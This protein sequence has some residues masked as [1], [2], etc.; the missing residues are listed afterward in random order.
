M[1]DTKIQELLKNLKKELILLEKAK[2]KL[3]TTYQKV[4]TID[5]NEILND[6]NQ[7]FCSKYY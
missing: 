6:D 4:L 3:A 5:L 1:N 7:E 2:S